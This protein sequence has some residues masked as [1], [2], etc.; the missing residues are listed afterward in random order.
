MLESPTNSV[1]P[2]VYSEGPP[3]KVEYSLSP[4]FSSSAAIGSRGGEEE[5]TGGGEIEEEGEEEEEEEFIG[6][7]AWCLRIVEAKEEDGILLYA[8]LGVF[9]L[10]PDFLLLII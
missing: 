1:N 5:G 3:T 9:D 7:E 6:G 10:V 4:A 8:K 2:E